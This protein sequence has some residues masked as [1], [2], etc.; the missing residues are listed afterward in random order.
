MVACHVLPSS[1]RLPPLLVTTPPSSL[2]PLTVTIESSQVTERAFFHNAP[3]L[4]QLLEKSEGLA[5]I[6]S[7]RRPPT[8]TAPDALTLYRG[9]SALH[10]EGPL[11]RLSSLIDGNKINPMADTRDNYIH[12]MLVLGN[13]VI[14]NGVAQ[15]I[16]VF[17]S[18]RPQLHLNQRLLDHRRCVSTL[19]KCDDGRWMS[20]SVDR[21]IKIWN[22]PAA[23]GDWS[24]EQTLE[25]HAASVEALTMCGSDGE[26]LVSGA[27]N[28]DKTIKVWKRAAA[29]AADAAIASTGT[30][31]C[32]HTLT[33][34]VLG[35]KMLLPVT[36]KLASSS[37]DGGIRI[38]N[39]STWAC[40]H[41]FT[42]GDHLFHGGC[43]ATLGEQF[44]TAGGEEAD[45]PIKVWSTKT[46]TL[47]HS[48]EPVHG[49]ETMIVCGS[50]LVTSQRRY[51]D[52]GADDT[53]VEVS[54]NVYG[55][56]EGTPGSSPSWAIEKESGG[57]TSNLGV[58]SMVMCGDMLLCGEG[59][60]PH[61]K[62]AR[63]IRVTTAYDWL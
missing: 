43:I 55:A 3:K 37:F 42:G 59:G 44:F 62:G 58:M 35:I 25:G 8:I 11:C 12:A 18:M 47:E 27:D 49:V 39:T 34:H 13:Q 16:C 46:W 17:D 63:G 56:T 6:H 23:G 30:W 1:A 41:A 2:F 10:R 5:N 7:S 53:E 40:E 38:W 33:G 45:I 36:G 54:M 51:L 19:A 61:Q 60:I 32:Q 29:G 48:S 21:T 15:S 57:N 24:C 52:P 14:C 22:R 50:K 9:L 28:P 4:R 26:L 20:G 31:Q